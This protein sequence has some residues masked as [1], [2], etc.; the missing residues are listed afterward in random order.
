MCV[1][2]GLPVVDIK[3]RAKAHQL[4][5]GTEHQRADAREQALTT[6]GLRKWRSR[7][8]AAAPNRS[9]SAG[10]KLTASPR[11]TPMLRQGDTID[12]QSAQLNPANMRKVHGLPQVDAHAAEGKGSQREPSTQQLDV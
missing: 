4:K 3:A 9:Q 1:Q 7:P 5:A 12:W 8:S 2:A 11:L 10:A 6:Q